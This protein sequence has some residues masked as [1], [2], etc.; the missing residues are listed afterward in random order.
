MTKSISAFC[1][2]IF[3]TLH[4]TGQDIINVPE[5][6]PSIQSALFQAENGMTI[7]VAAGIYH[8]NIE[9]PISLDNITLEGE[10]SDVTIIDGGCIDRVFGISGAEN[11]TIQGFTLQ[12]GYVSEESQDFPII[13]FRGAGLYV[14]DTSPT[15]IDL[16][17]KDNVSIGQAILGG[18]MYC[19]NFHGEMINCK[20]I[21]NEISTDLNVA[22]QGAGF[23]A[24]QSSG[25]FTNCEFSGNRIVGDD[26]TFLSSG[27]GFY[28]ESIS[29]V[30]I[31]NCIFDNNLMPAGSGAGL[32][33]GS[34]DNMV[35]DFRVEIINSQIS[36]NISSSLANGSGM[37]L[38]DT[39]LVV[40]IESCDFINNIAEIDEDDQLKGWG[41]AL[42]ADTKKFSI[43]NSNFINN[44]AKFGAGIALS[45]FPEL[46][47]AA[48]DVEINSCY[49]ELNESVDGSAFYTQVTPNL[50]LFF[51]NCVFTKNKGST[52]YSSALLSG[53]E[54]VFTE[55]IVFEHCTVAHN[56]EPIFLKHVEC[57]AVNSIFWNPDIF[58]F[59]SEGSEINFLNCVLNGLGLGVNSIFEDPMFIS[60]DELIPNENSPCISAGSEDISIDT[61]INGNPRPF[62]SNTPPDIGAYELELGISATKQVYTLDIEFFP[63]PVGDILHFDQ[64]V[65]EYVIHNIEGKQLLRGS[66]EQSL[67]VNELQ[68]GVYTIEVWIDDQA[69]L[70]KFVKL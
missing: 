65:D 49:F 24:R 18:G 69:G 6:Y 34:D 48:R 59:I 41:G 58:E 40:T 50:Q 45:V 43:R 60:Q 10:G 38:R 30:F 16:V 1:F 35:Q 70:L 19:F 28:L 23:Y 3:L 57:D 8:E 26:I 33:I 31:D 52:L 36:N 66:M 12:N 27:A 42:Y 67:S 2:L 68:P 39:N 44:T 9:W 20:I 32:W 61:D 29:D 64:P 13:I 15:L 47:G 56:E 51:K 11:V 37:V 4:V 62:P 46:E 7:K 63:N 22:V 21:N 5:D 14:F 25:S 55:K 54:D 53:Q 17:I